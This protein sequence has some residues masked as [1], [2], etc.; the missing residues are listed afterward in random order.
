MTLRL[1]VNNVGPL[2]SGKI[3]IAPLTVIIGPNN[4]GKS[5]LAMLTY[6]A[7]QAGSHHRNSFARPFYNVGTMVPSKSPLP[8][9]EEED[10]LLIKDLFAQGSPKR[11]SI[12]KPISKSIDS[13]CDSLC[14][15]L[16]E[17]FV[18]EI[19]RCFGDRLQELARRGEDGSIEVPFLELTSS[20]RRWTIAITL[21][22]G[23]TTIDTTANVDIHAILVHLKRMMEERYNLPKLWNEIPPEVI[24]QHMWEDLSSLLFSEFPSSSYYLPAARSGFLQSHRALASAIVSRAPLVGIEDMA[25]PKLTGVIGDFIGQLLRLGRQQRGDFLPQAKALEE[26]VLDG[27]VRLEADPTGYRE[28]AFRHNRTDL[29]LRRTSSMVSELAPVALYLRHVLLYGDLLII[30]EPESHLHPK[31]QLALAIV[32]ADAVDNGLGVVLTTHSD[33]FLRALNNQLIAAELANNDGRHLLSLHNVRAILC[34]M[35]RSDGATV[36]TKLRIS[37]SAGIAET[38][39]ARV[40]EH[41]Y[42]ETTELER[43]IVADK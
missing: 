3:E 16:G 30:E 17:V 37:K 22:R 35:R 10:L 20:L 23:H 13:A 15:G 29:P 19:E 9:F 32:L 34:H 8:Q 24:G 31:S 1:A 12:T 14:K 18:T 27:A 38:E 7:T 6:A 2:A 11:D 28:I 36:T 5:V 26:R 21:T 4:S 41:L 33:Y 40:A 42:S 25:V 39:F 43:R